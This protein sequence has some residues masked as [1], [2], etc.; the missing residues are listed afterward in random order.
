MTKPEIT[1]SE[2]MQAMDEMEAVTARVPNGA[3]SMR[4]IA[5]ECGVGITTAKSKV[6]KLIEANL[7]EV[8]NLRIYHVGGSKIIPH[9]ILKTKSKNGNRK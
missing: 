8:V 2:W 1:V 7:C 6:K 4:Q 3:K 9:Y 5:E